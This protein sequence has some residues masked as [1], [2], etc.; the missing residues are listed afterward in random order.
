MK[1][2]LIPFIILY[3]KNGLIAQ[4]VGI[5]TTEPMN[6]LQVAG[7]LLVSS[8]TTAINTAPQAQQ[9]ITWSILLLIQT[10]LLVRIRGLNKPVPNINQ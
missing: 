8:P 7:N 6:K 5:G 9:E 10:V 1:K 4:N 3:N 2:L